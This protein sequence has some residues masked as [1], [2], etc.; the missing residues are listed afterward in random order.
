MSFRTRMTTAGVAF[1]LTLS[2]VALA[3]EKSPQAPAVDHDAMVAFAGGAFQMGTEDREIG[4]YGD[5]WFVNE[6]PR[7]RVELNPFSLDRTEVT[8]NEYALFLTY[9]GGARH[10]DPSMPIDPV[11]SG[12]LPVEGHGELPIHNVTWSDADTF[13]RWAG[14]RLPSEAQWE[15]AAAGPDAREY[16]WGDDGP[17]CRK[18]NYFTGASYCEDGLRPVGS[19]PLGETPDGVGDLGG[20][21]AEWTADRYG[22]Y[23]ASD[24]P[25][26]DPVGPQAGDR[27]V[28]RGGSYV[29]GS[30][31]LRSSARWAADPDR[32]SPAIGF[33]CAFVEGDDD[34][35][36]RGEL[37][38]PE[39]VGRTPPERV[40]REEPPAPT[41]LAQQLSGP[42]AVAK[43]D[44]RLFVYESSEARI[45]VTRPGTLETSLVVEVAGLR[46]MVAAQELLYA[47]TDEGELL[48]ID[49]DNGDV[50][51]L[52]ADEP[53]GR[54]MRALEQGVFW[55]TD[56]SMKHLEVTASSVADELRTVAD[57]L[58]GPADY[59]VTDDSVLIATGRDGAAADTAI[60]RVPA[61]GGAA[62]SILDASSFE[63]SSVLDIFH[64]SHLWLTADGDFGIALSYRRFPRNSLICSLDLEAGSFGCDNYSPP[65]LDQ[66]VM[67]VD[68]GLVVPIRNSILRY[69]AG[70]SPFSHLVTWTRAGGVLAGEGRVI[71]TDT[72]NGRL[73][74]TSY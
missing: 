11:E 40:V 12:Y 46:E 49:P 34:E 39:D 44:D 69:D 48:K 24:E 18:V 14:K 30:R 6:Q 74:S 70:V 3:Q 56:D 19:T 65:L 67:S 9:A 23:E 73:Y 21:V 37:T 35:A 61:A 32:R 7:H 57:G 66:P 5:S 22:A 53:G 28:V 27:R 51:V 47:L 55:L 64:F 33:R 26:V 25:T 13:C 10:Y 62:D 31:W 20:N 72:A 43:I 58:V 29:E 36:I 16:P 4:R 52:S 63:G 68:G 41:L 15:F 59:L 42:T 50:R 2:S 54:R 1:S 60:L 71:W 38:L 17:N 45:V 8:V